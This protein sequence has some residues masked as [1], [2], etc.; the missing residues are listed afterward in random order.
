MLG[1]YKVNLSVTLII[2]ELERARCHQLVLAQVLTSAW[3]AALLYGL[4]SCFD[5]ATDRII[6]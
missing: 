2:E 1:G 3:V 4:T 5:Y 6:Y